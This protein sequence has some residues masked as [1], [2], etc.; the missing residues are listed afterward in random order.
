MENG[1]SVTREVLGMLTKG[2]LGV[3]RRDVGG[4]VATVLRGFVEMMVFQYTQRVVGWKE[5]QK[6]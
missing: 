6:E 3:T 4:V 5:E 1:E 2:E